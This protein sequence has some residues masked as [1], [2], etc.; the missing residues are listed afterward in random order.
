MRSSMLVVMTLLAVGC[1]SDQSEPTETAGKSSE[2]RA[3]T[4]GESDMTAQGAMSANCPMRVPGTSVQAEDVD[5]GAALVFVTV[6][7]DDV[8]DLR[9]RVR[10]MAATQEAQAMQGAESQE[11]G[12]SETMRPGSPGAPAAG[13]KSGEADEGVSGGGLPQDSTAPSAPVD[14][15]TRVEDIAGGARLVLI[16]TNAAD[17]DAL[18]MQTEQ[19]AQRMSGGEC[20]MTPHSMQSSSGAIAD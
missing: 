14:V 17:V 4:G 2:Q 18:R 13:A 11:M 9:E 1:G 10:N 5:G 6:T 8:E 15:D 7:E 20:A 3:T 12:M 16:A 19:H